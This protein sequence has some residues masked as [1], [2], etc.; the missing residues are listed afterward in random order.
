[1]YQVSEKTIAETVKRIRKLKGISAAE[2][3]SKIGMSQAQLSR[4]ESG[5]QGI[6]TEVLLKIASA[7]NIPPFRFFMTDQDWSIWETAR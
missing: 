3:G 7:L 2:L 4:L 5:K 6:R 1:M